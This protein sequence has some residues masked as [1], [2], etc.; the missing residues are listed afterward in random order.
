M[1]AG[2][3]PC[4]HP[5]TSTGVPARL[6]TSTASIGRPCHDRPSRT[7]R[8]DA[9]AAAAHAAASRPTTASDFVTPA[10]ELIERGRQLPPVAHSQ[11]MLVAEV[12]EEGHGVAA[13]PLPPFA[14][15]RRDL[16][17]QEPERPLVV[18]V[19]ERRDDVRE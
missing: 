16:V 2:S 10:P 18:A 11:R 13:Q 8:P 1:P 4:T 5:K 3:S 19:L 7:V 14:V 9:G 15:R 12:A 6:P 17:E